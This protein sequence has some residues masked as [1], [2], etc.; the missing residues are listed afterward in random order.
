VDK[1]DEFY[2]DLEEDMKT[3]SEVFQAFKNEIK[4]AGTP[5]TLQNPGLG[6]L[7]KMQ[8]QISKLSEAHAEEEN[9]REKLYES[10]MRLKH[11]G[12]LIASKK[13]E[14]ESR[15]EALRKGKAATSQIQSQFGRKLS[16][17]AEMLQ[18]QL[19]YKK[20]VTILLTAAS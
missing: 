15:I 5:K 16:P 17:E 3:L 8:V 2:L 14:I 1:F 9:S 18:E 4:E 10:T 20:N 19:E 13:D 6:D 12:A 7:S 11:A